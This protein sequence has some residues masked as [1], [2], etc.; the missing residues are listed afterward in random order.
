MWTSLM[1]CCY[2][3]LPFV[4]RLQFTLGHILC[5]VFVKVFLPYLCKHKQYIKIQ[6][7]TH[8]AL[9]QVLHLHGGITSD[10]TGK[11]IKSGRNWL[12]SSS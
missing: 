12:L 1:A 2:I 11:V 6:K 9:K 3:L 10:R 5:F 8:I 4:W 7:Q